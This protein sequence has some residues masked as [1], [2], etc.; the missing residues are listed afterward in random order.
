M[1]QSI[2]VTGGNQGIGYALCRQLAVDRGCH[3][4]LAARSA[5]R[6]EAAAARIRALGGSVDFLP[7]DAASD[8]SVRNAARLAK[9]AL[10]GGALYGIV[11]NAGVGLN[12]A[13]NILET[14]LRGPK[15]VCDGFLPLLDP[16]GGRIVNV[17]SGSGPM[18]VGG[19]RSRA[20][21]RLLCDPSDDGVTWEWIEGHAAKHGGGNDYGL[22]KALL[23]CYTGVLARAH[24]NVKVSCCTPGFIDTRMTAGW[25]ASK[26]PEE[27]T[28]SILKCLFDD[29]PGNGWYYGSDGVRSPYHFMRNPGEPAY[30]GVNPFL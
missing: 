21:A 30:D 15:R 17:G 25:G 14:N 19:V 26:T 2:L 7:L 12:S 20:D 24:P 18:Y 22:S 29:L 5:E 28:V 3:V 16:E 13:G 23:A 6:G 9:E 10:A 4:Y 11:N 27:G 8:E 1:R